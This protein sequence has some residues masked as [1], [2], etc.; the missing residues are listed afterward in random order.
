M[1]ASGRNYFNQWWIAT[2]PGL[3][4]VSVVVPF[5]LVGDVLRDWMDPKGRKN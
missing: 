5:N 4:I 1:V 2:F 3:A